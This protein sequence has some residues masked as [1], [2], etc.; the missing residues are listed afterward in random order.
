MKFEI[1]CVFYKEMRVYLCCARLCECLCKLKSV[2]DRVLCVYF[3]C[4]QC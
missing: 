2:C 3:Y 4:V 1:Q